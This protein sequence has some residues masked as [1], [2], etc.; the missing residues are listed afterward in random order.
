MLLELDETPLY[1]LEIQERESEYYW[2][3]DFVDETGKFNSLMSDCRH[4][5]KD[6]AVYCARES[7][8]AITYQLYIMG[9]LGFVVH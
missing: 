5:V 1:K 2:V 3:L 7:L 6:D 4:K 9:K 8:S